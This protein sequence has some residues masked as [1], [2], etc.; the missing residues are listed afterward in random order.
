MCYH[1]LIENNVLTALSTSARKTS[2][3]PNG[4]NKCGGYGSAYDYSSIS[5]GLGQSVVESSNVDF[6]LAPLGRG[7]DPSC[8]HQGWYS[9]Y[10][11]LIWCC[12]RVA[13]SLA[14]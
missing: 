14:S 6:P 1:V 12:R 5:K 10:L 9:G 7:F 4:E 11:Y 13:T 3:S 2:G 8:C